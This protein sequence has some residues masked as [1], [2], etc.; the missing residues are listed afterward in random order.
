MLLAKGGKC[1]GFG[2]RAPG[3]GRSPP[4]RT[5]QPEE[6][7]FFRSLGPGVRPPRPGGRKSIAQGFTPGGQ[8]HHTQKVPAGR[9]EPWARA[10][11]L[12][13]LRGF[14]LCGAS[15]PTVETVGYDRSSLR[16]FR[17]RSKAA[18]ARELSLAPRRGDAEGWKWTNSCNSPEPKMPAGADFF[19]SCPDKKLRRF[20]GRR[21]PFLCAHSCN[22]A[23]DR[24]AHISKGVSSICG[25]RQ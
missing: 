7:H 13:P 15:I 10:L 9:K 21:P 8:E 25:T 3:I 4:A 17:R 24:G 1:W 20:R 11:L 14:L 19:Y 5:R 18:K 12:S 22:T 23:L 2:A 6:P 16:D